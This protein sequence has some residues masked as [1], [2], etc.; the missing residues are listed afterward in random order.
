L[1]RADEASD[2]YG[3]ADFPAAETAWRSR[4]AD[5]PADWAARHN[6]GLAL[7]Q[8]DHWAEAT[9]QWT[10]AFL[11][12]PRSETTRWDLALGLQNSG[13][14]PPDIVELVRGHGRFALARVA[15]PGEWQVLLVVGSLLI[16]AALVILLLKGYR[17][18]GA[19][20][21]P[22]ALATILFAILLTSAATIS[23]R[24]YG[25][26]AH[27]DVALVWKGSMLR[28]IPTEA[29]TTQKTSP[30]SAGSIAVADRTFIG[31]THL[32]FAGGQ[33]GWVRSEDV[34]KLYR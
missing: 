4:I 1:T 25:Q 18:I 6:L 29:D 27:P 10:S 31:W 11:L 32:V 16:A 26:L 22:T 33:A 3:R 23:L 7:A 12:A 30:L 9:A 19:W 8:Q 13:L 17:R 34:A 5:A 14:A 20:A 24:A 2:A 28:S 15:S 21:R